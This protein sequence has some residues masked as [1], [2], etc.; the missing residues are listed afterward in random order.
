MK[1]RW[2]L[3]ILLALALLQGAW[4]QTPPISAQAGSPL[5]INST[6]PIHQ[7]S[8]VGGA[9]IA[10]TFE[11]TVEGY[12]YLYLGIGTRL[13]IFYV[14]LTG[15]VPIRTFKGISDP[16]PGTIR[17]I[18]MVGNMAYL[19]L[20]EYGLA[21]IDTGQAKT[22]PIIMGTYDTP[23]FANGL[24][25]SAGKAYV[26]DGENGVLILDVTTPSAITQVGSY[27]TAGNARGLTRIMVDDPEL[28]SQLYVYV[29]DGNNG[30][31]SLKLDAVNNTLTPFEQIPVAG[32]VEDVF[33]SVKI[34][35][36]LF[37]ASGT[38]GLRVI[39]IQDP[40][41]LV[42]GGYCDT[43][44]YASHVMYYGGYVY[45][46]DGVS[47]VQVVNWDANAVP[48]SPII[49]SYNT[50]GLASRMAWAEGYVMLADY[51]ALRVISALTP[52]APVEVSS[53]AFESP[54]VAEKAAA[55]DST[56]YLVDP[57]QGLRIFDV[58]NP[59]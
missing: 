4:G 8:Q 25:M 40:K 30:L 21:V 46:A 15:P 54:T 39:K 1:N 17:N 33:K 9:S 6:I 38:A 55:V 32:F 52:S 31:V 42:S 18:S 24:W 7:L 5:S 34:D 37:L 19:T 27:N 13:Y 59:A 2:V 51:S 47:G 53:A 23:G 16:L 41:N 49:A 14:D 29:A 36:F 22:A 57:Y 48:P 44:G 20:G 28:G 3:T 10:V 45:V 56:V 50:T 43:P 11:T 12:G 58:S 26:A 35:N